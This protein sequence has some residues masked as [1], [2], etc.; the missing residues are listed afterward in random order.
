MNP[1]EFL[2]QVEIERS[3]REEEI[4]SLNNLI[5]KTDDDTDKNRIRRAVICLL[6][7]H[8]EGFV[9]FS[10]N[11][12]IEAINKM[13]LNCHQVKPILAAAVY[14]VDFLKM[15]N[16][17]IKNKIFKKVLPDDSHLHRIYRYEEFFEKIHSVLNS[18]IK[19]EDGYINTESNVG[20][21]ILQ[22]LLYQVGLSHNSLDK[23]IGPLTRL[24]NKR[25]N[26]SHG[27]DKSI[28]DTIEYL[29]FY[30]CAMSIMGELSK[31]LFSAFQ[32][33]DFLLTES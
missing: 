16:P 18:K 27:V 19:I 7:A 20:K 33:K 25:N 24:K 30:N 12:Y 31:V 13:D 10:F 22:K 17:D 4:R 9:K 32:S 26:I 8:V 29:Q 28:I 21:E 23:V 11:L 1:D 3:W 5:S 14:Y 15:N 2:S 6:Y